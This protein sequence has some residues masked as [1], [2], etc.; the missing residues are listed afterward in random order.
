MKGID[1]RILCIW[2]L[3]ALPI[4]SFA[5]SYFQLTS[6]EGSTFIDAAKVFIKPEKQQFVNYNIDALR[7][8]LRSAPQESRYN[9]GMPGTKLN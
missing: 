9:D 2:I 6:K 4:F 1:I 7:T 8:V 3:L 5:Q